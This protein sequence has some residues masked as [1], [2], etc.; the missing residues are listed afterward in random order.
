[1]PEAL[2][3]RLQP[4]SFRL[5]PERV[6]G[7][8]AV[9]DLAE[10]D[11]R[12]IARQVV[13]LEDSLKRAFFAMMA[14]FHIFHVIGN[15]PLSFSHLHHLVGRHK[16][17]LSIFV[18]KLFDEPGTGYSVDFDVFASNPFHRSGSPF[19]CD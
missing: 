19:S 4:F 8:R 14:Q 1:M 10:Q 12:C 15:G 6:V 2:S 5:V 18:H 9:D 17:K 16:N 11:Q 7:I 3:N 13:L